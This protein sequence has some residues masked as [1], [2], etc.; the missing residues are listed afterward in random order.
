MPWKT[1]YTYSDFA[2]VPRKSSTITSRDFVDPS[3]I[4]FDTKLSIPMIIAPMKTICGEHMCATM[5]KNYMFSFLPRALSNKATIYEKFTQ[6][7][8]IPQEYIGAAIGATGNFLSDFEELASVGVKV[9]CIDT[10]N[11]FQKTVEN[12]IK[13]IQDSVIFNKN[14]KIITGCVASVEGY[15]FL[16]DL[17]VDGI[18]IGIGSGSLCKT[19][20][21]T[22]IGQGVM[23]ILAEIPRELRE[24]N[25]PLIIADG[26]IKEP[27]DLCKAIAMGAHFVIVGSAFAGTE[28]T[29]GEVFKLNNKKYKLYAGEASFKATQRDEYI[30][31][32]DSLVPY[33]KSVISVVKEYEEGLRSSMSYMNCRT[34]NEFRC[35]PD[36]NIVLLSHNAR[37]ERTTHLLNRSNI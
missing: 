30:E 1:S 25:V 27:G 24:E 4:F 6:D 8:T 23:S 7:K 21:T 35:Q 10:A 34:I 32:D 5:A 15:L 2:L 12:A 16:R 29:P 11:G 3:D 18:R 31:G 22:G 13:S 19:S 9:F 28:E 17:G 36:E 37:I 33:K 26:G 20:I 14:I